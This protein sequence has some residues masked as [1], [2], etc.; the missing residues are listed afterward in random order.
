MGVLLLI[1]LA[2]SVLSVLYWVGVAAIVMAIAQAGIWLF[3]A[4][5]WLISRPFVWFIIR[6]F[7]FITGKNRR[8]RGQTKQSPASQS[9]TSTPTSPV[10]T[11]T[12]NQMT[13]VSKVDQL[14][15]LQGLVDSG[16]ISH[17]E[18]DK[19]KAELLN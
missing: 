2:S 10:P 18:F 19:L 1:V 6:P 3:W 14:H 7:E 15:R 12:A 9:V 5:F 8:G 13:V 4:I 16:T 17:A 11:N